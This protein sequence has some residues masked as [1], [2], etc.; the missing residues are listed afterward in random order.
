M[1]NNKT[2]CCCRQKLTKVG[3][4]VN[5]LSSMHEVLDSIFGAAIVKNVSLRSFTCD[6][7]AAQSNN[8]ELLDNK[9]N[10]F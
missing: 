4:I 10:A 8:T 6:I 7:G 1:N 5:S 2:Q 3:L 9:N